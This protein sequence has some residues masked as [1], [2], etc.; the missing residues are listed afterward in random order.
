MIPSDA[1]PTDSFPTTASSKQGKR[2]MQDL[3]ANLSPVR[4]KRAPLMA[5]IS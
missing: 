2:S 3:L 5:D 1:S 4:A